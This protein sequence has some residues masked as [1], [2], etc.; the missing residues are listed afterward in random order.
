MGKMFDYCCKCP[1]FKMYFSFYEKGF[2]FAQGLMHGECWNAHSNG[3]TPEHSESI[4]VFIPYGGFLAPPQRITN[5]VSSE[6]I[7][8]VG[9]KRKTYNLIDDFRFSF[10]EVPMEMSRDALNYVLIRD[11][12]LPLENKDCCF[13][14]ERN[15]ENW[16]GTNE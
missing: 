4:C 3:W 10:G 14:V 16:N 15:I 2:E 1:R 7:W 12:V 8:S 9:T 5:I 6:M 13:Y 11:C